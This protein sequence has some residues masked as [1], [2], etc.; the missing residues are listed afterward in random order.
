MADFYLK[1]FKDMPLAEFITSCFGRLQRKKSDIVLLFFFLN[2]YL[3]T[4]GAS[5]PIPKQESVKSVT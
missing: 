4:D 3:E 5:Q 1:T 2:L